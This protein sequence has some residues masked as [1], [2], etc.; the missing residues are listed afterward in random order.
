MSRGL[1]AALITAISDP[2][3]RWIMLCRFE[4]DSGTIAFTSDIKDFDYGGITYKGFGT[5]GSVSN[6]QESEDMTPAQYSVGLSGVNP[7]VLS[8][9]LNEDYLGRKSVCLLAALDE[10]RAIIDAP[11]TYFS[12]KI[13]EIAC[14]FGQNCAITVTVRDQLADWQRP[15]NSRYT[16]Q[17]QKAKYPNDNGFQFVAGIEQT[18][19][20]WPTANW[21]KNNS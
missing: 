20:I 11:I 14:Q 7:D 13:D 6:I 17:D 2:L 3:V 15:H 18:Q 16:D 8:A 10:S 9:I 12:G 4:F 21:Y 5:L 19:I 1:S